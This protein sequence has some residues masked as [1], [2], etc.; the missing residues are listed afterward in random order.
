MYA[1]NEVKGPTE[2][3]PLWNG[4]KGGL[5]LW[6]IQGGRRRMRGRPGETFYFPF[7]DDKKSQNEKEDGWVEETW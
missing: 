2:I 4:K 5:V 1:I 6:S 7:L 3:N